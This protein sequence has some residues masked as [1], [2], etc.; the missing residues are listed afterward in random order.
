M[1]RKCGYAENVYAVSA[2]IFESVKDRYNHESVKIDRWGGGHRELDFG[3]LRPK[4]LPFRLRFDH[5][6]PEFLNAAG[7]PFPFLGRAGAGTAARANRG[8]GI[9]GPNRL[10]RAARSA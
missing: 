6:G 5:D 3:M 4:F 10:E 9:G 8:A 1:V 2:G 7:N